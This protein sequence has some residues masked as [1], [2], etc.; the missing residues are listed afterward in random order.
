M[1]SAGAEALL[2]AGAQ[3]V[4]S[5]CGSFARLIVKGVLNGCDLEELQCVLSGCGSFVVSGCSA[6]VTWRSFSVCS[7]GAE[8]LQ[9]LL[10]RMTG[11]QAGG[12]EFTI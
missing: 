4:L 6:G 3:C 12:V 2:S 1:C 9:N 5:G 11:N 10:S 8:A 7:V